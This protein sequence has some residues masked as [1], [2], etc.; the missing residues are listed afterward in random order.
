MARP[1]LPPGGKLEFEEGGEVGVFLG[2]VEDRAA[3]ARLAAQRAVLDVVVRDGS[4][5]ALQAGGFGEDGVIAGGAVLGAEDGVGFAAGDLADE[6]LRQRISPPWV[7]SW[8][9]PA[10][11]TGPCG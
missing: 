9:G 8:M 2:L 4:G 6:E 10:L 1:L 11:G 3:L 7:W 5:P